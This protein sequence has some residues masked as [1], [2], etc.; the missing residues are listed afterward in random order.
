MLGVKAVGM[1]EMATSMILSAVLANSEIRLV[2]L[3]EARTMRILDGSRCKKSCQMKAPS[4]L[5]VPTTKKL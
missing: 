5:T 1:L 3:A 4:F 2:S